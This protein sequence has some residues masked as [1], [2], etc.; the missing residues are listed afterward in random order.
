MARLDVKVVPYSLLTIS[1]ADHDASSLVAYMSLKISQAPKLLVGA[2]VVLLFQRYVDFHELSLMVNGLRGLGVC[3]IAASG[4][5]ELRV[6][7]RLNLVYFRKGNADGVDVALMSALQE[8]KPLF[9]FGDVPSGGVI[10]ELCRDVI[11]FGDIYHGGLVRAGG[12]VVV[13]GKLSGR[14]ECG[15][16]GE[17][18]PLVWA[19][20]FN[21]QEIV[22]AGVS[23]LGIKIGINVSEA[24]FGLRKG[25]IDKLN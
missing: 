3:V 8:S 11:V 25:I 12:S 10:E 14:V 5:I 19:N 9:I 4:Q 22:I 18:Q 17:L 7:E 15:L 24:L 21:A 20:K 2:P 1:V 13:M 16:S 23:S 6:L